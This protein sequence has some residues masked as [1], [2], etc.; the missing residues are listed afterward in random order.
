[1]QG[2]LFR[3]T[4]IAAL[5]VTGCALAVRAQSSRGSALVVQVNPETHLNPS[6]TQLS[7]L[8]TNPGE[9]VVS[10]PVT[11]S[12]WVRALPNRQIRLTAQPVNLIGPAGAVPAGAIT[13]NGAMASATEGATAAVCTSG[14]FGAGGP[15]QMIS[16]WTQSG[17]AQC[18]VTFTLTTDA[19]WPQGTYSGQIDFSLLAR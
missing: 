18:Q 7:F 15:Q 3:W 14:S 5:A 17:I 11:I 12:A 9:T 10:A 13:W 4:G 2:V 1:L 19:A 16:G 6:T 8:V